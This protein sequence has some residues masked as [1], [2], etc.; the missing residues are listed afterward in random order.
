MRRLGAAV[1]LMVASSMLALPGSAGAAESSIDRAGLTVDEIAAQLRHDPVLV[2]TVMG[3][4]DTQGAHER[5]TELASELD[6]PVYVVIGL[7]PAGSP[8]NR[9]GED[10]AARL[11]QRLGEGLY[12]I[13]LADD[14]GE[15]A[16]WLDRYD[17][18]EMS[19]A[20]YAASKRFYTRRPE[21]NKSIEPT[22]EAELTLRVA[23]AKGLKPSDA[24]LD[25]IAETASAHDAQLDPEV[26]SE[27][28]D[29]ETA[30][31]KRRVV[32]VATGLFVLLSG[33]VVAIWLLRRRPSER[34]P[35]GRPSRTDAIEKTRAGAQQ[36]A[37]QLERALDTT[38]SRLDDPLV[39]SALLARDQIRRLL[40]SDDIA[41]VAGVQ[42]LAQTG[43]RN[44]AR[45]ADRRLRPYRACF[46]NPLHG[47]AQTTSPLANSTLEV[48]LCADCA[49][50]EHPDVLTVRGL[51]RTH[52]YYDR[53]DVWART[54]FGSLVD[55]LPH[56]VDAG[57]AR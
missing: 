56:Q 24:V 22:L 15:V 37:D 45:V 47:E 4:G 3:G 38:T 36:L 34:R 42:V 14:I 46:A 11:H 18:F 5:L 8:R 30:L 43:L 28:W 41:D 6:Y 21:D 13:H 23:A 7:Q 20:D 39:E 50:S 27:G 51:F 48:P 10:L 44:L 25:D 40:G 1:G 26:V 57:A 17:Q 12:V 2:Q 54:G 9:P 55:D 32:T 31:G 52:P 53:D 49:R 16:T 29:S 19:A 35:D 33:L